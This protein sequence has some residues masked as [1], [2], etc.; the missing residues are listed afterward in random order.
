MCFLGK[1]CLAT[2]SAHVCCWYNTCLLPLPLPL[3]L[4]LLGVCFGFA[5]MQA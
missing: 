5:P 4:L 2:P 3:L 1:C